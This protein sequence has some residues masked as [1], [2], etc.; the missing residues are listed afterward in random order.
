MKSYSTPITCL[1]FSISTTKLGMS[2]FC[3]VVYWISKLLFVTSTY[4]N[5][6]GY[7][8][9]QD[10]EG[11]ITIYKLK[12]Q[13]DAIRRIL[14]SGKTNIETVINSI[15]KKVDPYE[16]LAG[17]KQESLIYFLFYG[18]LKN[19]E[20]LTNFENN[21]LI[22]SISKDNLE[23]NNKIRTI[24]RTYWED[25]INKDFS[26]IKKDSNEVLYK[27]TLDD[28]TKKANSNLKEVSIK[29]D[30]YKIPYEIVEK[31][32]NNMKDALFNLNS[33]LDYDSTN[34]KTWNQ[35]KNGFILVKNKLSK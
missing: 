7:D 31:P 25:L 2:D 28:V 23:S 22:K 20:N 3:W 19:K 18:I 1:S 27:T 30:G 32:D 26:K 10:K 12:T 21:V 9:Y 16:L 14:D 8:G 24:F 4:N 17:K 6:E 15:N 13:T 33:K 11:N 34:N 35:N 5:S 29:Q